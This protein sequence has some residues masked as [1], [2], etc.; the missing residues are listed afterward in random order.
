MEHWEYPAALVRANEL[1]DAKPGTP[2]AEELDRLADELVAY[3]D[4]HIPIGDHKCTCAEFAGEDPFCFL[5]G[6]RRHEQKS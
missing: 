3:E 2:E 4:E 6:E 5:H 1:M